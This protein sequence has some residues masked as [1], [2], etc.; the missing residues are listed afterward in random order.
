M[1]EAKPS[2]VSPL[3]R[4]KA[5]QAEAVARET[6]DPTRMAVATVD[7]RGRPSVRMVLLKAADERGFVFYTN[8][9]SPKARHLAARPYAELCIHWPVIEKQVR[10]AGQVE[11]VSDE[12]AD[13][14]FASR[15]RLS[16]LGAWASRQSEP[17][18]GYYELEREVAKMALRYPFGA[19][20]R[21]DFWSGFRVKPE[22]IEFWHQK[23]FRHHERFVA[24]AEGERWT[25]QW[26]FP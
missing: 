3:A 4:F 7:D 22:W 14:Y 26:I 25:E 19:V 24:H 8:L 17:M 20:P 11:R 13:A 2:T 21:P 16:Q 9:G 18:E 10:V 5:W 12:E 6:A 15:P 1:A 23:A